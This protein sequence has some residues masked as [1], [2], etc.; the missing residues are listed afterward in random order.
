M[1]RRGKAEVIWFGPTWLDSIWTD[2]IRLD[3][4]T[5]LDLYLLEKSNKFTWKQGPSVR[6]LIEFY[7]KT[8]TW[9][10]WEP[11]VCLLI[12]TILWSYGPY[13]S[14][15]I[16]PGP[17]IKKISFEVKGEGRGEGRERCWN[18][19]LFKIFW[20]IISLVISPYFKYLKLNFK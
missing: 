20:A 12:P 16:D 13:F 1:I 15:I 2:K 11:S 7:K 18:S 6:Y 14:K 17:W 9:R 4:F 19:K 8:G 10:E 5:S 3:W